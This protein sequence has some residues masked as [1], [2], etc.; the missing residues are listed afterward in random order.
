MAEKIQIFAP[1]YGSGV[2]VASVTTSSA[3][4]AIRTSDM[5]NGQIV[6]TN[7]GSVAVY[8]RTGDSSVVA[9]SADYLIPPTFGQ[10]VLTLKSSD[11]HIAYLSASSTSS[12]H[13]IIG[14]GI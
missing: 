6:V 5:G 7:T 4:S 10:I 11:T 14:D 8:V 3:S 1:K 9:T 13:V 2:V 12:L